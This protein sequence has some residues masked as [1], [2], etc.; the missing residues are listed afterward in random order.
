MSCHSIITTYTVCMVDKSSSK[1][2]KH[3]QAWVWWI[4]LF[5]PSTASELKQDF[6]LPSA[7][8]HSWWRFLF[9]NTFK[10]DHELPSEDLD[11]QNLWHDGNLA[12]SFIEDVKSLHGSQIT[13]VGRAPTGRCAVQCES[14]GQNIWVTW[15]AHLSTELEFPKQ[16]HWLRLFFCTHPERTWHLWIT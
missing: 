8:G 15:G 4:Q 6:E 3:L 16:K 13:A 5:V 2:R 11:Q 1:S 9:I 7:S 14:L 10:N 12:V